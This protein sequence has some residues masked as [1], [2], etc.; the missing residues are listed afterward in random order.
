MHEFLR[1]L[2]D[3]WP[4]IALFAGGCVGIVLLHLAISYFDL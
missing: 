1:Q 3:L 4:L 2:A